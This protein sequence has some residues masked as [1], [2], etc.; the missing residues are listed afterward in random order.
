MPL[1]LPAAACMAFLAAQPAAGGSS[2]QSP[3]VRTDTGEAAVVTVEFRG[4]EDALLDNV[5]ALSSLHRLS[6]SQDLDGE[7]IARLVQRAPAEAR[8][9]L[10][11]FG[12]YAP[13][14]TTDL[15]RDGEE[16]RAVITVEPGSPVVLVGQDV[17]VTGPG[18]DEGR[19]LRRI[20]E[21]PGPDFG[22]G[23]RPD[24]VNRTLPLGQNLGIH[25]QHGRPGGNCFT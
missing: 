3:C 25:R 2:P 12:Y 13:K 24:Q 19:Q 17:E 4:V 9:A 14:V 7:M 21:M 20:E 1:V 15:Q 11:P 22:E 5:R 6:G 18:R 8:A 10:R 23:F 16:W